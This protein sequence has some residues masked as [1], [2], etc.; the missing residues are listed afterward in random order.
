[1][2]ATANRP[3]CIAAWLALMTPLPSHADAPGFRPDCADYLERLRR[4]PGEAAREPRTCDEPGLVPAVWSELPEF[5][6][7]PDRWRIVNAVGYRERLFDPYNGNNVLK[8]DRPAFGKDWFFA[9]N[10]ISDST[11]EGRSV[12]TP[13]A[14]ATT[15][16]PDSTGIFGDPDQV[17]LSQTFIIE[18][19]LYKGETIFKP[20]DYEFRFLPVFSL[21]HVEV[22]QPGI[23]RADSTRDT[24]RDDNF[25]GIQ[26]LFIDKH[27][28][29]VSERYDFDSIR[30]GIQPITAD[31]R[32]FLF[33]DS[34]VGIRLFGTR[35]T[36][37]AGNTTSAHFRRLEKEHQQRPE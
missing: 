13:V 37:I 15:P 33:Q 29:N 6:A 30:I 21:T 22:D 19:V 4:R 27:L 11:A 16:D 24:I 5:T 3:A 26:G 18:T 31:F 14:I 17:A 32:G 25:L 10:F 9:L 20:P 7:I 12:P 23:L 1:M 36:T 35:V 8:G 2:F 34:P 28:R